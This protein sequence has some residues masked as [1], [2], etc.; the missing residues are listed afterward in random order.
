VD[1]E[2]HAVKF[3]AQLACVHLVAGQLQCSDCSLYYAGGRAAAHE[4]METVGTTV[5]GLELNP[6]LPL[7][8]CIV[9]DS[10]SHRK[11]DKIA[12]DLQ[13]KMK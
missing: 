3:F 5:E 8:S 1:P 7:W 9:Y 4:I 2:V 12:A 11:Y 10:G 6:K 13:T